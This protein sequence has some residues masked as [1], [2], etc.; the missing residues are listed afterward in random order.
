ML[1]EPEDKPGEC[2]ARLTIADNHGDNHATMRCQLEP[3]HPGLHREVYQ[4][5]EGGGRVVVVWEKDQRKTCHFCS[6]DVGLG[7]DWEW[8]G[9]PERP[10]QN[11]VACDGCVERLGLREVSD[12]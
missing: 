10:G 7:Y 3:G 11:V 9:N 5:A 8:V 4:S 12:A 6:R 1:G 2:N